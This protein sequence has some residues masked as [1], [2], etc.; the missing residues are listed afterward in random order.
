M[1]RDWQAISMPGMLTVSDE[2]G[3]T[4][5]SKFG[6]MDVTAL[7]NEFVG[8]GAISYEE[9]PRPEIDTMFGFSVDAAPF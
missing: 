1:Y 3:R 9:R 6:P 4:L 8:A 2:D 5:G 7:V